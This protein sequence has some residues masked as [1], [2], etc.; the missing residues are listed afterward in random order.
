[1]YFENLLTKS[2]R[3]AGITTGRQRRWVS[4]SDVANTPNHLPRE[5]FLP[6]LFCSVFFSFLSFFFYIS[7]YACW[8]FKKNKN[9][10][11]KKESNFRSLFPYFFSLS[12]RIITPAL[13]GGSKIPAFPWLTLSLSVLLSSDCSYRKM[14]ES[15]LQKFSAR[16]CHCWI[17]C[18]WH[19][20]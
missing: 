12:L 6:L 17:D 8:R 11:F 5:F 7:K 15:S 14:C 19:S 9:Q 3:T 10:T 13:V 4:W 2:F 16:Y 1:M 20:L 18:T